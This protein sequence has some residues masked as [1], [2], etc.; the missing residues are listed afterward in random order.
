MKNKSE[1]FLDYKFKITDGLQWSLD[2]NDIVTVAM[3]NTGFTNRI[4]QRFFKKPAVSMITL[5]G[6]GSYIFTCIDG[7]NSVYDI[8]LMVH[9]KY[10]DDAEPLYE[11][12]SI[13]MKKLEEVGFI[14][15]A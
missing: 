4:A 10:L 7:Q 8:G 1:N 3:E 13:Y 6:M 11:R 14:T 15:R 9:E 12:L 5:E 2:E